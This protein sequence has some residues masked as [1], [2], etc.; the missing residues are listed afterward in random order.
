MDSEGKLEPSGHLSHPTETS[1]RVP[2]YS[3]YALSILTLVNFLNYI[4]RQA[5]PA[6]APAMQ[7]ELGLTDTEIGAMEAALL[8]SFTVL[9]PLFGRL[10]DRYSRTKLMAAAAVV[11]S[12]ATGLTA[13]VDRWPMLPR[14]LHLNL[15]VFGF[16]ALSSVALGLCAVRALVGV[17]ESSYSTIT[18]TLIADYFPRERRAT[19]L[20]VFQAAIPM[21]F[22]LGYVLGALLA[23]Y[24]GWRL[25]FMLVGLPGIIVSIFVWKLSEPKRGAH[26][27]PPDKSI[28]AESGARQSWWRTTRQIFLTRDWFLSTAGYTAVTFVLGAFATWATLMLAR[29][30]HMS[31]TAAAVVLGIVILVGGAAGT[32]GGGWIADRVMARRR[33]GYFLVCAVSSLLAIIPAVVAL[34]T[35]R[36]MFFLPAI[37][38]AVVLLFINNAPFH[39]ILVNSVPPAIRASAMAL[40]IVVIHACGDVISR[41]G[42]GKLSDSLAGGNA[43]LIAGFARVLGIDPTREHL[44]AA[45]L[46]VPAAL[47]LSAIFFLWGARK[48]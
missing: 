22:A 45:L 31:E 15:P 13:W 43:G 48:H 3:Y 5:L 9:A 44:T 40:N 16:F 2:R 12:I 11:W 37:F 29:D 36:P 34:V 8:F 10:G 7:R 20:G 24:F 21:G 33:N 1:G 42:V 27:P 41:F 4:D 19:A 47:F 14:S 39:A 18:P 30:K 38:F 26:D 28:S 17:G 6:V 23:H 32:F 25:A 46:V 35:Q